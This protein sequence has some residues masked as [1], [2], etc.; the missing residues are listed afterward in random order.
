MNKA[1]D[2]PGPDNCINI[3]DNDRYR[4][5]ESESECESSSSE[6]DESA[7][8][9]M[10]LDKSNELNYERFVEDLH[11][12]QG[13]EPNNIEEDLVCAEEALADKENNI[14]V[15]NIPS[16]ESA[17]N[18]V[19]PPPTGSLAP[20]TDL[21]DETTRPKKKKRCRSQEERVLRDTV[22]YPIR[23]ICNCKVRGNA[24]TT[25]F[26]EHRKTFNSLFW[27]ADFLGRRQWFDANIKVTI[28]S[29]RRNKLEFSS[30]NISGNKVKVCKV[31]CLS[32]L[33]LRT[34]RIVTEF[35][36]SK[37]SN[38]RRGRHV[39]SNLSN[40]YSINRHIFSHQPL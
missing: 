9:P 32:T 20:T 12:P 36:S 21:S 17:N 35:I 25:I 27:S 29:D 38:D 31:M 15:E 11:Q 24:C 3:D 30:P 33:G 22:Q 4:Y 6:D 34:D 7:Y 19:T 10:L 13:F 26:G 2:V 28:R 1:Y 14:N 8:Q 18:V 39:P 37:Q 16:V 5:D 23:D 40:V